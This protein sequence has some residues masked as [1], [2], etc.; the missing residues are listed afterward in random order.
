MSSSEI[1]EKNEFIEFKDCNSFCEFYI[2]KLDLK[3]NGKCIGIIYLLLGLALVASPIIFSEN[4]LL[5]SILIIFVIIIIIYIIDGNSKYK[6]LKKCKIKKNSGKESRD[7]K[8]TRND[9]LNKINSLD[10]KYKDNLSN[11]EINKE[12]RKFIESKDKDT[13]N[14]L[15]KIIGSGSIISSFIGN[16]LNLTYI[17]NMFYIVLVI[18]LL[19]LGYSNISKSSDYSELKKILEHLYISKLTDNEKPD[20]AETTKS[21]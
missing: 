2:E 21:N 1:M 9:L 15:W 6:K 17:Y 20:K 19:G 4:Y 16:N 14:I 11:E 3:N 12:L 7:I 10:E 8:N 18:C 13:E 5:I